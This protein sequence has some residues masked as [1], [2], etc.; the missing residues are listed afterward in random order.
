MDVLVSSF[1]LCPK[2][3]RCSGIITIAF[4]IDP[5]SS[6]P[7][8]FNIL[9]N[10]YDPEG[11]EL[12]I[13]TV[14]QKIPKTVS[15]NFEGTDLIVQLSGNFISLAQYYKYRIRRVNDTSIKSNWAIWI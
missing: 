7:Y 11:Y 1:V 14:I 13:D 3:T 6:E 5:Y 4:E 8:I 12:E 10:D 2:H 9:Q 15:L